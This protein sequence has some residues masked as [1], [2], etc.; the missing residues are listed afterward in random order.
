VVNHIR[1][2]RLHKDKVEELRALGFSF[3]SA[4]IVYGWDR[5]KTALLHFQRLEGNL[6]VPKRFVVPK[7]AE[8][9][10]NWPVETEGMTLGQILHNIRNIGTYKEWREDMVAMGIT[11][12]NE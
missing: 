6:K 1:T 2:G 3:D 9:V 7:G 10:H 5:I 12:V 4:H 11:F 8:N